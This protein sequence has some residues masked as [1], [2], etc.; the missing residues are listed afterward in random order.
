MGSPFGAFSFVAGYLP[1]VTFAGGVSCLARLGC[2]R[3]QHGKSPVALLR[4]A[5][6]SGV[7]RPPTSWTPA[8]VGVSEAS[9]ARLLHPGRVVRP[10]LGERPGWAPFW[11]AWGRLSGGSSVWALPVAGACYLPRGAP[12]PSGTVGAGAPWLCLG[13]VAPREVGSGSSRCCVASGPLG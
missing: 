5:C 11:S 6:G 4:A 2:C 9:V 8:A 1:R 13:W 12:G 7:G 10:G 3:C